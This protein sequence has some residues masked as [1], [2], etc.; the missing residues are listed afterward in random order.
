MFFK[1]NKIILR[2]AAILMLIF[3]A[4]FGIIILGTIYGGSKPLSPEYG[5]IWKYF[6]DPRI[7]GHQPHVLD[8]LFPSDAQIYLKIAK[9]WYQT[10]FFLTW[11]P[12]YPFVVRA[13]DYLIHNIRISALVVSN[14]SFYLSLL[15]ILVMTKRHFGSKTAWIAVTLMLFFPYSLYLHTGHSESIFLLMTVLAF[16]FFEKRNYLAMAT[17]A[18]LACIARPYG[19]IV[20]IAIAVSFIIEICK[21]KFNK[22]MIL[23]VLSPVSLFL[24][25]RFNYKMTGDWLYWIHRRS[26]LSV[27]GSIS[28]QNFWHLNLESASRHLT[29]E[30]VTFF[31]FLIII[32]ASA[33]HKETR[34]KYYNY[35]LFAFFLIIVPLAMNNLIGYGRYVAAAFPIFVL[36]AIF[37]Q[38]KTLLY[39]LLPPIL[40]FLICCLFFISAQ[41]AQM[42][43]IA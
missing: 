40:V 4:S 32:L 9:D 29:V 17:F 8:L 12:L 22:G 18:S 30:L 23:V 13:F 33:F 14:L 36:F 27:G 34:N 5:W 35:W 15:M 3:L 21:G 37:I 11:L 19:I 25:S 16:F 7:T 26:E 10:P 42:I 28:L 1:N 41:S 6:L 39:F 24:F 2:D 31:I 20:V 38:R 43:F